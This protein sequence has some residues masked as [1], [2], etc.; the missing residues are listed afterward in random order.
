VRVRERNP[1]AGA[2]TMSDMTDHAER[3]E[4]LAERIDA[5]KEFL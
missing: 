1:A 3:I 4:K 2:G 5:A